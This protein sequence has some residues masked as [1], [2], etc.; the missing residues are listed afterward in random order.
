MYNLENYRNIIGDKTVSEI[1]RKVRKFYGKHIVHINSTTYGGGV[2]EMLDSLIPLMNKVGIDTGW[3]ILHGTP[4]F[5]TIT[6]KFHNA[7][8]GES[9]NLTEMKKRLYMQANEDF[10][11]YA[12]IIDNDYIIIHDPQPLSLIKFFRKRQ[13]WIWRCHIDLTSPNKET[14]EF[15]KEFILKY[16]MV[17]ISSEKYRNKD[18][19][20]EQRIIHPAIDPMSS[21][22]MEISDKFI[23]KYLKKF[24]IPNDKPIITQ[25]SRFDKWKDPE[26]V[27]DVFK[28]VKEKIDCRLILCGSMATDDPEGMIIYER[29][30][31]KEKKLIE[32]N[33]LILIISDS[34]NNIR[35]NVLQRISDVL[36]QKSLREGFGLT[37]TE[38]LW[39]EKPVV[40]SNAGGIP[41]QIK[42][43]ENGFLLD[44]Y[45]KE[46]FADRIIKILE[47]PKLAKE[48]GRK[49]KEHVRNNFLITR[50][51]SD[52]LDLFDDIMG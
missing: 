37:V 11:I 27:V 4:D 9:I 10:S 51:L 30:K 16:D 45:N 23:T 43:G 2:A 26:G 13:P 39:K 12:H 19:P 15:L 21:K 18:L 20:V 5:F 48:I 28:I 36:I 52:Y 24:N 22:N 50:L 3:K 29:L 8:Q 32:N 25:I 6:K 14:W 17:I 31:Q 41:L 1:Y 40:A 46:G 33:D 34:E 7:L 49:G 35:V 42:D 44:P 47:D 38:A